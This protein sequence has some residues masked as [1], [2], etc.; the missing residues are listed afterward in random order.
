MCSL[1]KWTSKMWYCSDPSSGLQ[2]FSAYVQFPKIRNEYCYLYVFYQYRVQSWYPLSCNRVSITITTHPCSHTICQKSETVWPKGP[3]VTMY[4]GLRGSWS[5]YEKNHTNCEKLNQDTEI[6][7]IYLGN[8]VVIEMKV[9]IRHRGV[10]LMHGFRGLKAFIAFN[11]V[12]SNYSL[13]RF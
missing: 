8:D 12:C 2:L 6:A 4:E 1:T 7:S 13:K 5:V 10:T 3:W 9:E 11:Q